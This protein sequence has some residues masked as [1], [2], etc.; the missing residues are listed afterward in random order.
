ML[1][2]LT[3][4]KFLDSNKVRDGERA[5]AKRRGQFMNI[6][7]PKYDDE[8]EIRFNNGSS[9]FTPLPRLMRSP[10]DHRGN[11]NCLKSID[12]FSYFS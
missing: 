4:L 12:Y 10:E 1:Y 6:I 5:E 3:N 7:R 9:R 2:H 8:S 11:D